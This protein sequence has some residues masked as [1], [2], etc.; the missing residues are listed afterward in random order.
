MVA[1]FNSFLARLTQAPPQALPGAI[2][3]NLENLLNTRKGC[4]SVVAE[5]GLGDY[6]AAVTTHEAVLL[7]QGELERSVGRYEPR[8][9]APRVKL[10]GGLGSTTVRFE[11]R[12][13]AREQELVM[14]VDIDTRTRKVDVTVEGAER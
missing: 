1:R 5:F 6:E 10:L 9:T 4:G 14:W 11:L 2:A 13:Q 12:G 7:L 3:R 8:I